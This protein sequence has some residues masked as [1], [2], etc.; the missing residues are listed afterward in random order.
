V[1]G[2]F[3]ARRDEPRHAAPSGQ[4]QLRHPRG[5]VTAVGAESLAP[6]AC[7][8]RMSFTDINAKPALVTGRRFVL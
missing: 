4:H 7:Q 1:H 5:R 6:P 8:N 2:R 3:D